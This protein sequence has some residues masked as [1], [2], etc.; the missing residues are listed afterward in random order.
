MV[1]VLRKKPRHQTVVLLTCCC[2][3]VV[4]SSLRSASSSPPQFDVPI[5]WCVGFAFVC[6][7]GLEEEVP[8]NK[9][10][11]KVSPVFLPRVPPPPK[12][13]Q[14]APVAIRRPAGVDLKAIITPLRL[15]AG[16]EAASAVIYT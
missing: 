9:K 5:D 15:G 8:A 7:W 13:P 10:F 16:K 11:C 2:C 1:C 4:A 14:N 12:T 3:C 6:E